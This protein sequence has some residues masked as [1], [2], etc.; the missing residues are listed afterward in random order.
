MAF[1]R[2]RHQTRYLVDFHF[3]LCKQGVAGSS[4]ATSTNPTL[5]N[6]IRWKVARHTSCCPSR[7]SGLESLHV[8]HLSLPEA[9]IYDHLLKGLKFDFR[10]IRCNWSLF[11]RKFKSQTDPLCDFLLKLSRS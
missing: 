4:P 10:F 9:S 11:D 8:H 5:F 7:E 1:P 3:P 6:K 2:K